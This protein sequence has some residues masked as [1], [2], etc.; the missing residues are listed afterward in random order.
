[1]LGITYKTAW[2]I[3]HRI[4]EAMGM[5]KPGPLGGENKVVEADETYVGG[6]AKNRAYRKAPPQEGRSSPWSSAAARSAAVPRSQRHCDNA[7]ADHRHAGVARAT[8]MTDESRSIRPSAPSSRTTDV[9]HSADEYVR[10][11]GFI[12]TNTAEGF[13]SILKRGIYGTYHHVS[14]AHLGRYLGE[15]DFRYNAPQGHGC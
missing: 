7:S 3:A 9:N 15:F 10:L 2:F 14:E 12:H 6:K 4:R 13:F 11:G 8:L 5:A 1:M